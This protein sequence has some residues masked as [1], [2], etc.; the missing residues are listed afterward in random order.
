MLHA[1][2]AGE[3]GNAELVSKYG[4][5]LRQNP[6][7]VV[8]LDKAALLAGAEAWLG[9]RAARRRARFLRTHTRVLAVDAD[10]D[11]EEPLEALPNAH[12]SPS[13]FVAL[14]V[15]G[16]P[17]EEAATWR[18][19]ADAL[20]LPGGDSSSR[21]PQVPPAQLWPVLDEDGKRHSKTGAAAA[22]AKWRHERPGLE[23]L[24][25]AGACELLIDVVGQRLQSFPTD[26]SASWKALADA[27]EAAR[28][29]PLSEQQSATVT[30]LM[31]RA[32]EQ[33]ILCNLVD[34]AKQ[35][36]E[37]I[38][39]S[40]TEAGVESGAA[41]AVAGGNKRRGSKRRKAGP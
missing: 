19:V 29:G 9:Q 25:G 30:A 24:L 8:S 6:F 33:E 13:L 20:A 27:Q 17:N 31:L 36:L 12:V 15:L 35:R 40:N 26:L 10:G 21:M 1:S 7:T 18:G 34:A 41:A 28:S 5:A 4:F 23:Q 22:E 2:H 39:C 14:R 32:T 37:L 16:A 11:D 38:R 3:L